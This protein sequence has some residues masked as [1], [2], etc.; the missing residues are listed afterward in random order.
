MKNIMVKE[1]V[2]T[3]LKDIKGEKSFSDILDELTRSKIELRKRNLREY[4]GTYT[5]KEAKE[6][7]KNISEVLRV[8]KGRLF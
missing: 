3:R 6:L 7:E 2:Y 8:A 1:G 5:D 4:F